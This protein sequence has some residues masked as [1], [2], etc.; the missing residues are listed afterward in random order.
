LQLTEHKGHSIGVSV[1]LKSKSST[2]VTYDRPATGFQAG[3]Q[4]L[5][6]NKPKP[7]TSRTVGLADVPLI[8]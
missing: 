5:S 4:N 1:T 2:K 6:S 8:P 7:G 3:T